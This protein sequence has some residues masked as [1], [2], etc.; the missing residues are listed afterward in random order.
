MTVELANVN[1]EPGF[2]KAS[3]GQAT[4]Y[5]D[6]NTGATCSYHIHA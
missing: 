4:L 5:I 6:E 2:N 3:K 1:E